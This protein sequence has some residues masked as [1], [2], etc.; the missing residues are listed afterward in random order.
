MDKFG[1]QDRKVCLLSAMPEPPEA[2]SFQEVF[3]KSPDKNGP[4]FLIIFS[5][6]KEA[7]YYHK[8]EEMGYQ[9]KRQG[10]RLNWQAAD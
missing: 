1:D 8:D 7:I 4:I 6:F 10:R 9:W 5:A 2:E 3:N